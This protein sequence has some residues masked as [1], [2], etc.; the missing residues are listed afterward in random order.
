MTSATVDAFNAYLPEG[1]QIEEGSTRHRLLKNGPID[2]IFAWADDTLLGDVAPE[3]SI[4]SRVSLGDGVVDTFRNYRDANVA[5]IL[6]GAGGGKAG[7]TLVDFTQ[8]LGAITRGDDILLTERTVELF[9]NL[10]FID[11]AAKAYGVF[12]HGIYTSKT[13]ARVDANFTNMDALFAA[14]GIPL[15]EVQQVY[16]S[17][18]LYYN[19]NRT[20]NQISKEIGP[21]IDLFWDKVN[22]GE[23]ERAKEILDS[24]HLSVSRINGLPDELRDRLREQV[25][26]GFK[27]KTTWERVKQLR[28]MGLETEA[29]QLKEITR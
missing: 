21:R 15:E 1:L 19:T 17:N 13:G 24:I 3:V 8:V 2:A 10:K 29:E 6:G 11:N 28:R 9:R 23:A 20:Y 22:E 25:M 18:S 27:S 5:E 7:D 16:D 4:A 14:L 12:K 26:N